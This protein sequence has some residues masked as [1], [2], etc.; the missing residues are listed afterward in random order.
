MILQS[1][2]AL[3]FKNASSS[4]F[5]LFYGPAFTSAHDYWKS[6]S[7]DYTQ[8]CQQN[9]VSVVSS[10]L[11]REISLGEGSGNTL[12]YSCLGNLMDRGVRQA[13]VHW[14]AKNRTQLIDWTITIVPY[15]WMF[16][17]V[18]YINQSVNSVTQWCLTLCNPMGYSTPGLP[19]HHEIQEF[20]NSCPLS[21][22]CH[23]AISYSVIPF[24]SCLQFFPASGSFPMS[25]FIA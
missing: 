11:S 10:I 7:C 24:F 18:T 25:Q 21:Q 15:I 12:Q 16:N 3:Q 17:F 9:D 1:T 8:L 23:L 19:V 22:W 14:V 2:L 13:T 5:S 4:V 20:P 6:H